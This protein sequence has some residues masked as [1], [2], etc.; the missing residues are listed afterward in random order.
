MK[1]I[2]DYENGSRAAFILTKQ[3]SL[4]YIENFLLCVLI[5]WSNKQLNKK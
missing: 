3:T 5:L 4:F 1:E 2:F